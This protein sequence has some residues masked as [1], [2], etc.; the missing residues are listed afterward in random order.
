MCVTPSAA[1]GH[2]PQVSAV[3]D[4]RVRERNGAASALAISK[5]EISDRASERSRAYSSV[6]DHVYTPPQTYTPPRTHT[7]PPAV[8]ADP[9]P[10]PYPGAPQ[11]PPVVAHARPMAAQGYPGAAAP[12]ARRRPEKMGCYQCGKVF[13]VPAGADIIGCPFCQ[14]HNRVPLI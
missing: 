12:P 4:A 8:S 13:G 10:P 3:S 14:A 9:P 2:T 7:P 6:A 11:A 1:R 5:L